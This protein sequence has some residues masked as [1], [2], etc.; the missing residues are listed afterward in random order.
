MSR[1]NF[2]VVAK[3]I[4]LLLI[5]VFCALA[6]AQTPRFAYVANP[7]DY[8]ITGYYMNKEG[9]MFPNGM[10]YTKDKFPATLA[11]D[12]AGQYIYTASRTSDTAPIYKIDPVTGWLSET[13]DS[14]F[15]TYLRSPFSY[16]FHPSGRFLYVAGRGG[17]VA[18]F[19]VNQQS[20]A[21]TF[22]PGSPFKAGER[23]RSLTVHPSG[24]FIY[25]SNAYTNNISAYRVDQNTGSLT[26]LANSPFPAGEVGPF[27]DTYSKLPD[28]TFNRGGLPYYIASHPSGDFVYVTNWMAASVSI[29]RVN[30]ETGDL[31]L[32]GRPKETGLTPYAVAVHPSGKY[33][34][35]STWGGNDVYVYSVDLNTGELSHVEGSPFATEGLKPVDIAFSEDGK[36]LYTADNNSNT[37][38][39]FSVDVA[40]GKLTLKDIAM[41]RAGSIDVELVEAQQPVTILPDYA[42]VLDKDNEQLVSYRIDM[43][44]GELKEAARAKT[45]SKPAAVAQDPRNRFV[46]VANAGS[47]NVSA[48]AIDAQSGQLIEVEGSPYTVGKSPGHIQI[49]ANGWYLYTLNKDSQDISVFLIHVKKG[50]L[51]EAQGSPVSVAKQPVDIVTDPTARYV[52]VSNTADKSVN[53]YRYR[54]AITPSIFEIVDYGSPFVFEYMPSAVTFDPTGR[55]AIVAYNETSQV[56]VFYVHVSTG[57]LTPIKNN[58]K[59]F[60]LQGKGVADAVFHPDG[61]YLYVL[62]Q[63]SRSISQLQMERLGG[64]LS[65]IDK[66]I[67]VDGNPRSLVMDPS[68]RYLYVTMEGKK[69]LSKYQVDATSGRLSEAGEVALPFIPADMVISR[70]FQ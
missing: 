51:A 26:E 46:Y 19:E 61:R 47:D 70:K 29:F 6:Q 34:M 27:D 49:D 57:A 56:S 10:V 31:T 50:Q 14:H 41:T 17:G 1:F 54:T 3:R 30:Q 39:I 66:P 21:L 25:A 35:V 15:D 2:D 5:I 43:A 55:F 58:T 69:G 48:F 62:N 12:A 52:Y 20:G 36:W 38:S 32:I 18:G 63:Q 65:T 8:T 24:K 45:G 13:P 11:I 28:V 68:G 53:V 9:T 4:F 64:Q 22:V 44:T 7:Y 16:D 33:V 40:T 67:P 60:Q 23:T 37:V 59:P 42:F